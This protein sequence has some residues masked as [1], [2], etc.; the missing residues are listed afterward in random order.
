MFSRSTLWLTILLL[1]VWAP[2]THAGSKEDRVKFG[3]NI[4]VEEGEEA[5]SLVCFGC[6]IHVMGRSGDVVCFG[7]KVVIE[8][9]VSGDVVAFGGDVKLTDTAK[10]SGDLV[11]LGGQLW[12]DPNAVVN[13][14]VTSQPGMPILLLMVVIPLLPVIAIV[15]LVWWLV[16]RNRRPV[17]AQAY[18]NR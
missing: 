6:S 14:E 4:T 18:P 10:V 16:S 9:A 5:G 8:G 2:L 17:P 1:T 13:G 15:A 3:R 12:R 7:G 11:T